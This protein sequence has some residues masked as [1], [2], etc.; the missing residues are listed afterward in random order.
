MSNHDPVAL[1][2]TVAI[3]ELLALLGEARSYLAGGETRAAI[4]T[5]LMFDDRAE[6][7]RAALRLL[8]TANRR[9]P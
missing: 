2:A 1:A 5:L 7:L 8:R 4:G 3:D 6:D 9:R